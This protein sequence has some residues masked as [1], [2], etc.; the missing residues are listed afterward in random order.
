MGYVLGMGKGMNWR[1]IYNV[2]QAMC[3]Y[4]EIISYIPV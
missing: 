1:G 3:E 4:V 2:N